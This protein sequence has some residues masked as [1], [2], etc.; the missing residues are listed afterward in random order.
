MKILIDKNWVYLL[1]RDGH[2]FE[3]ECPS[4]EVASKLKS[5][6]EIGIADTIEQLNLEGRVEDGPIR[7]N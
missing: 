5:V 1:M 3:L 2:H 6:I 4:P 7:G